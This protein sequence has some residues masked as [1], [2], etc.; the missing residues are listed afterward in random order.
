HNVLNASAACLVALKMGMDREVLRESL[1]R[2]GG[3]RRRLEDRG[4]HGRVRVFSDYAHH[5]TEVRAVLEAL[6]AKYPSSRL[7]VAY[8]GHQMWRTKYFMEDFGRVLA[9]F[10][11]VLI[12]QTYSVREKDTQGLPDGEALARKV[13]QCGGRSAF[14]GD[15]EKAPSAILPHLMEGDLLILMGAGSVD[16]ISG[17]VEQALS[18]T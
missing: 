4:V 14:L 1:C 2:F 17:I 10:D 13:E 12:L 16:D 5:P 9:G 18:V 3:V 15:L 7:V 6:R 11:L 8:Q